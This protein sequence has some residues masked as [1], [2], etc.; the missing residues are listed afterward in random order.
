MAYLND[1]EK[2]LHECITSRL[3]YFNSLLSA[4]FESSLNNLQLIKNVPAR[5]LTDTRKGDNI[6]PILASLY[7]V[8]CG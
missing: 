3:D 5:I 2:L 1:T 4:S 6:S 7:W 8:T